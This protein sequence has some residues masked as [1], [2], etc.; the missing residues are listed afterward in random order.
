MLHFAYHLLLLLYGKALVTLF[1]VVRYI[2]TF[3]FFLYL[4][5]NIQSKLLEEIS[6]TKIRKVLKLRLFDVEPSH[7][8]FLNIRG[9]DAF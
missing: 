2:N 4:I 9:V 3:H 8:V 7:K 5:I 6:F 1:A